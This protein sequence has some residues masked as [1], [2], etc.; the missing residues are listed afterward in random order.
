MDE[1]T[2]FNKERWESL[3]ASNVEYSRPQLNLDPMTARRYVDPY[4]VMG[5]VKEKNVLC[6][7]GG[8][9]Q[10]S[11]AFNLLGAKVT[12]VDISETQLKRDRQALDHYGFEATLI[13]GDMRDLSCFE[14]DVFEVVWHAFSINFIPD[15]YKAFDEVCRVLRPGGLYRLE[16]HSPFSMG[17]DE[18][19]WNGKGYPVYMPYIDAEMVFE[20][21]FWDIHDE[22]GTVRQV[23]GPREFKHTL[24]TVINGLIGRGF[25]LLGLWEERTKDPNAEL[26][27]WE[28]FKHIMP[29]WITVW[30][31]Y[32]PER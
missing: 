17:V 8:G 16:W 3:A 5:D 1:I 6:L 31:C 28:H 9:G 30:T 4:N 11:A 10:Q 23:E 13:Q 20:N 7:A 25:N 18:R 24:S 29:P 26:G 14:T 27:T 21:N 19:D 32:Q 12:V 22:D 15:P 2:R